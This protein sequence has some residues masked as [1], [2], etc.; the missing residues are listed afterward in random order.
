MDNPIVQWRRSHHLSRTDLA[1]ATGIAR[2]SVYAMENGSTNRVHPKALALI[3]SV[4]GEA[5]AQR[6]AADWTAWLGTQR[7]T[8]TAKL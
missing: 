7:M 2:S 8:I 6:L 1:I 5:V 3:A 4:D